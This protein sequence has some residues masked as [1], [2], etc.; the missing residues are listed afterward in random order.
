MIDAKQELL[1][2]LRARAYKEGQFQLS[3]RRQS[4]FYIDAK[5]VTLDPRGINLVGQTFFESLRKHNVSAVGGLT[6]GADPIATA[7]A[8]YASRAG[9]PIPAFVVRKEAK[10]HGLR[11]YTEGP[12][13]EGARVAVVDDVVTSG[14]SVLKAVERV[15]YEGCEVAVVI[16][17][18]DRQ[19]GA[20]ER[21]EAR[22]LLFES[23]FTIDDLKGSENSASKAHSL[24]G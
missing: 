16:C 4:D 10:K 8:A 14:Q 11:K 15:Q 13:P 18:V 19:E 2:L 5:L 23:V 9:E 24:I 20:R 12:L 1:E 3:S 17:L 21:V 7:V 22:G 6:L